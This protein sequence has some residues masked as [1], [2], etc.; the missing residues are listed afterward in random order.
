VINVFQ[1]ALQMLTFQ[2]TFSNSSSSTSATS[3]TVFTTG[4][5]SPFDLRNCPNYPYYNCYRDGDP[6]FDWSQPG[7]LYGDFQSPYN[8][9]AFPLNIVPPNPDIESQCG[10][11]FTSTLSK[12]LSTAPVTT[13]YYTG[14]A[15]SYS[16]WI[17]YVESFTWSPS[18][19]CC[20]NCTMIG[21]TVQILAWP[22]PAPSPPVS[23]LVDVESNYTL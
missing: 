2:G 15:A 19:P 7:M 14:L 11:S 12:F 1:C 23:T 3:A 4:P 17:S 13:S 9:T 5:G 20:L 22:T 18:E 10:A 16:P 8:T 21:G 6:I